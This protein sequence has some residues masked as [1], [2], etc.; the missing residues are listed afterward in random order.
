MVQLIPDVNGQALCLPLF[1][2]EGRLRPLAFGLHGGEA[3]EPGPLG[4]SVSPALT[5]QRRCSTIYASARNR[6]F[7]VH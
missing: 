5:A 6:R 1:T 3:P 7:V 2:R 4:E